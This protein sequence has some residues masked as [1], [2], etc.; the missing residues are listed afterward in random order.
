[1]PLCKLHRLIAYGRIR[2]RVHVLY[3]VNAHAKKVS[4]EGLHL[5][6]LRL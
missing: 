6:Y 4:D 5:P 2:H 1:M 3:L